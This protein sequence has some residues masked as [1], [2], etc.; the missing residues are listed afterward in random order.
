MAFTGAAAAAAV[1]LHVAPAAAASGTWHITGGTSKG[2]FTGFNLNTATLNANNVSL[3]CKPGAASATGQVS[4]NGATYSKGVPAQLGT[5]APVNFGT[6]NSSCGLGSLA[7]SAHVTTGA[8]AYQVWGKSYNATTGVTTGS[9]RNI[10]ASI[11]NK[12][13]N[14]GSLKCSMQ[15]TNIGTGSP[16]PG[17]FHNGA[18]QYGSKSTSTASHVLVVNPP[19]SGKHASALRI[20]AVSGCLGAFAAGEPAWF[21]AAYNTS[22]A[23]TVSAG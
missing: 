22:P 6:T 9:I 8:A 7:I 21:A 14:W 2:S 11:H 23:L 20:K 4:G 16:L 17:S 13:P 12:G 5:L 1:G 19:V 3:T 10:S 15:V 18:Y